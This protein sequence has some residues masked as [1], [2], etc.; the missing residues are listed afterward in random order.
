MGRMTMASCAIF[1]KVLGTNG[2]AMDT[3]NLL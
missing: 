3:L 2:A 1:D